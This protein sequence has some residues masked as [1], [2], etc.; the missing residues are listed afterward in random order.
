MWFSSGYDSRNQ[1]SRYALNICS[2]ITYD[3]E[4]AYRL[5]IFLHG[6]TVSSGQV[7]HVVRLQDFTQT[8]PLDE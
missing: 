4:E 2:V 7:L 3:A 8:P 6:A 1:P 5:I